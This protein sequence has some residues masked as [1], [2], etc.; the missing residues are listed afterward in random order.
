MDNDKISNRQMLLMLTIFRIT[1]SLSYL[2]ALHFPPKNQ[3]NWIIILLSFFYVIFF[4]TPLLF[5]INKFKDFNMIEC[6]SLIL[7]KKTTKVIKLAYGIY[8]LVYSISLVVIESQLVSI[9][10]L[11]STPNWAIVALLLMV[12][13][14]I[15]SKGIIQIF[16]SGE[17]VSSVA[18]L[19]I[20]LLLVLGFKNVDIK[21][22]LP[23]LK[24]STIRELNKGSF[25][26]S[27][28]YTD[29]FL[30]SM[31][32]KH[33]EDKESINK[34]FIKSAIFAL[35]FVTIIIIV[36]Q[37]SLGVQQA[38]HFIYPFLIYSRLINYTSMLER[39]DILY[40][41]TWISAHSG[42]VAIYLLFSLMCFKDLFNIRKSK[43]LALILGIV[44]GVVSIKIVNRRV[45]GIN[46]FFLNEALYIPF[47]FTTII[48]TF[49]CIVYFFRRET[50]KKYTIKEKQM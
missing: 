37:T 20:V 38:R 3:D 43:A 16:W 29:I 9:S 46:A 25:L 30:L 17:L 47:I 32:A 13:L 7:G 41:V 6:F 39:I 5:L 26:T 44:V 14:Y 11:P 42:K 48:P 23:I 33:L 36:V 19:G 35:S 4:S 49:I 34:I 22:L 21:L 10:L 15:L 28:I 8:F 27:L 1:M 31:G 18:F 12:G 50:L 40:A 2:N 24:D 45:I